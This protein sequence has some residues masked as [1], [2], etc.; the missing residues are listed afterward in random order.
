MS[1]LCRR[2]IWRGRWC[3]DQSA[4][5][6]SR[7]R[8]AGRFA[9]SPTPG[10]CFVSTDGGHKPRPRSHRDAAGSREHRDSVRSGNML[11]GRGRPPRGG[12][13]RNYWTTKDGIDG[14]RSPASRGR[15]SKRV[16]HGAPPSCSPR[17]PPRGGVDR[18][19]L[20]LPPTM[21]TTC[22]P[23]AGGVDRNFVAMEICP[24]PASVAPSRGRGSKHR[25]AQERRREDRRSPAS[26]GRGSKRR[27]PLTPAL[28]RRR[29]P[30]SRGRGSKLPDGLA[31]TASTPSPARGGVDRNHPR[32]Q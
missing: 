16:R 6:L 31:S 8:N 32:P 13:D 24:P 18:N 22:R 29:S 19:V 2:S 28:D 23:L 7:H 21:A 17:R 3:S 15:G 27:E 30:A 1:A 20:S 25:A 11:S 5:T 12:V 4:R 14:S 10:G 9:P 26:R